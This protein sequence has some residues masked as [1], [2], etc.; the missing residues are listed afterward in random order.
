MNTDVERLTELLD[1]EVGIFKSMITA[2]DV[3]KEAA[4]KAD[5]EVLVDSRLEKESCVE[6][7][8]ATTSRKAKI[9]EQMAGSLQGSP[10]VYT[11]SALLEFMETGTAGK[12]RAVRDEISSLAKVADSKNRENAACLE[13]GL[14]MA[15]SS[16]MLVENICNP[17]TVY[18]KTGL[19]K[20][21]NRA[22]RLLSQN[23]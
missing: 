17:Q 18:K 3:E 14:R 2:L 12:L 11:F 4:I 23:Y 7:L 5:L 1:V 15:R 13:S 20:Q 19:V 16:L 22:G 9:V 6:R 10:G 21:N 8:K